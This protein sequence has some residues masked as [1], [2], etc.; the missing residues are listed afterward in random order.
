M[1][2]IKTMPFVLN[3]NEIGDIVW[4][5]KK[6]MAMQDLEATRLNITRDIEQNMAT[7][8]LE[9]V[10]LTIS[11]N[12]HTMKTEINYSETKS[13]SA[14]RLIKDFLSGDMDRFSKQW[15]KNLPN[16]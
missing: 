6:D 8:F 16:T 10:I 15:N 2:I 5:T 3:D 13:K 11:V 9:D 12:K 1:I 4:E 7:E 14:I